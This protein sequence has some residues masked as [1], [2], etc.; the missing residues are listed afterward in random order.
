M[1]CA[2][3][4]AVGGDCIEP[5][6]PVASWRK[7]Q[8]AREVTAVGKGKKQL[9]RVQRGSILFVELRYVE[10]SVATPEGSAT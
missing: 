2:H 6:D 3:F 7:D 1:E 9:E 8:S 10:T 5:A 4:A